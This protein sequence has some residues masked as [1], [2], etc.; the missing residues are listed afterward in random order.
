MI[1]ARFGSARVPALYGA[2]FGHVRDQVTLPLGVRARLDAQEQTLT[3][4]EAAVDG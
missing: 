2:S 1:D 3:L 4:L